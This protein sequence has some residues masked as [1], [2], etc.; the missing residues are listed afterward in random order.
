M[1]KDAG[2]DAAAYSESFYSFSSFGWSP[3]HA[4]E[5]SRYHYIEAPVPELYDVVADPQEK[6]N[7]ASQ[8]TAT[9][10]VL[11]DKLQSLLRQNPFKPQENTASGL[12]PDALEKLRALGYVA[13]RSP[14]SPEALA[15][16]LP[17]PK[18]KLWE[19][20]AILKA[21]DAFRA[22]D[23][24]AGETLLAQVEEKDPQMY[25]VPF[26]RGEAAARQQKWKE[27]AAAFQKCLELNPAFD[28]AMTGLAHALFSLGDL[29]RIHV[30]AGES[31]AIQSAELSCLVR[32]WFPARKVSQGKPDKSAAVAAY[33]KAVGI[34]PNFAPGLRELGSFRPSNRIIRMLRKPC[35]ERWSWDSA[36]RSCS[37]F[38]G[39]L[40]AVPPDS[41]RQSHAYQ[42]ISPARSAAGGSAPESGL[43]LRA[44]P[45][46]PAG[47]PGISRSLP[48]AAGLLPLR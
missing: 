25:V 6:N 46:T 32:A 27:A 17:D 8:Q 15:A 31:A 5:T 12:S 43:R 9:V 1:E 23:F 16:G 37:I 7:L 48:P 18:N 22:G 40:T 30:M 14:V 4:L 28:Q 20:N 35:P 33:Q 41:N 21:G 3:L 39:S 11:K 47:P 13:Y 34:Q 10:A 2:D 26:M 45:Q 44:D 42:K 36:M 38:W 19:F 24:P 29:D